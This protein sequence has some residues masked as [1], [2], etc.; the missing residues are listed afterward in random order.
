MNHITVAM[1]KLASLSKTVG[2]RLVNPRAL[3]F[4]PPAVLEYFNA[5]NRTSAILKEELP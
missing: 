3:S 5:Y 4:D 1:A 2:A